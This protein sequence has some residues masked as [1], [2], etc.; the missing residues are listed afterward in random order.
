MVAV[1]RKV[2]NF[3][4]NEP[5]VSSQK[6]PF[7]VLPQLKLRLDH[8]HV[9]DTVMW[10]ALFRLARTYAPAIV[11]P[12]AF[13]IGAIGY[14]LES[15]ISDRQTPWRQSVIE[16]RE[17]RKQQESDQDVFTVPKTI[18]DRF[19]EVKKGEKS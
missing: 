5:L 13:I 6:L 4:Y 14:K 1:G 9:A 17:E 19:A 7:C 16:R 12:F 10:P 3:A 15:V 18:F 11:F 8:H 2:D